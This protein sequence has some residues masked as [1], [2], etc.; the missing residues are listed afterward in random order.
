[1]KINQC[2]LFMILLPYGWLLEAKNI[3]ESIYTKEDIFNQVRVAGNELPS[4]LSN[5]VI[6]HSPGFS[7]VDEDST[8]TTT[9]TYLENCS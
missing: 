8:T 5:V 7:R 9:L 2:L 3:V 1:M 4:Y 6:P